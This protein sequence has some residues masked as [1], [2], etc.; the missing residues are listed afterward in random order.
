MEAVEDLDA[1]GAEPPPDKKVE[2]VREIFAA[3]NTHQRRKTARHFHEDLE[4]DCRGLRMPDFNHVYHGLEEVRRF[5]REWFDAWKHIQADLVWIEA[6]GDR[7]I[8]WEH[9]TMIGEESGVPIEGD[10]GWEFTFREGKISHVRFFRD[11]GEAL[12]AA[13]D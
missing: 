12:K 5:W 7:V 1:T 8:A 3:S 9:Q 13:G 10:I 4:Y 6:A 2:I 11:E